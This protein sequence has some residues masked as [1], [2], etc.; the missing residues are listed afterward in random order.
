ML[1]R[2]TIRDRA[3]AQRESNQTSDS[4]ALALARHAAVS[5][6]Q[7]AL[8]QN[9]TLVRATALA[10]ERDLGRQN[11]FGLHSGGMVL[12]FPQPGFRGAQA[13]TS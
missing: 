12:S 7:E 2:F 6:I 9:F 10:S 13:P 4:D 1:F 8:K 5:W 3:E 11:L